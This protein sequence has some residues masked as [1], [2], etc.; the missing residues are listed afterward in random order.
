MLDCWLFLRVLSLII[1]IVA[2]STNRWIWEADI[3]L[4]L[5]R[6]F[7]VLHLIYIWLGSM[8]G[9]SVRPSPAVLQK[10]LMGLFCVYVV[11]QLISAIIALRVL[12]VISLV[13]A[14][15]QAGL[16][17]YLWLCARGAG[18]GLERKRTQMMR[19]GQLSAIFV[20]TS[21]FSLVGLSFVASILFW[22]WIGITLFPE[23]A[24]LYFGD[25]PAAFESGAAYHGS[26]NGMAANTVAAPQTAYTGQQAV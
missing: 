1:A 11:S 14:I 24:L 17:A 23:D 3:V 20:L 22:V 7:I 8:Q 12:I 16:C 10:G 4:E 26:S 13:A 21:L 25:K 2:I 18:V 9:M 5:A 19:A 15:T 6:I